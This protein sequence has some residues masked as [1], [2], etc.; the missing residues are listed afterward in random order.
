MESPS[1]PVILVVDDNEDNAEI[2]RAFLDSRGFA[3]VV[4]RNGDEALA[5]FDSVRPGLVLST[6]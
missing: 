5:L 3:V 4:A 1:A 6:S 2:V